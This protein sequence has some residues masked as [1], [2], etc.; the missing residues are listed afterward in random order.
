MRQLTF[1]EVQAVGG[2][3]CEDLS[4]S[5]GLN[6]VSLSGSLRNWSSC[7]GQIG[8]YA[9]DYL[10]GMSAHISTGLPYGRPSVI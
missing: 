10:G 8:D 9:M 4:L 5:I 7:I 3:G 6:G 2:A 1:D